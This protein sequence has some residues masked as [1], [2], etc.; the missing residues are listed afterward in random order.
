MATQP[1]GTKENKVKGVIITSPDRQVFETPPVTKLQ[2]A[3]HYADVAARML[4][5]VRN[6][7]VSLL[8][9]PDGIAGQCFFQKH[10]GDGMSGR[11][12]T[13]AISEA[14]GD[15]DYIAL[16]T[17]TGLV[18]ASQMGT[19]EFHIWGTRNS[20]LARPDRIDRLRP[21]PG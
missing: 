5:F 17:A 8:R 19:I 20:T 21:R 9:C 6:R 7:P 16:S 2:V 3:Q 10:R 18:S 12:G 15:Q 14:D 13:V 11:I 4:P 1:D